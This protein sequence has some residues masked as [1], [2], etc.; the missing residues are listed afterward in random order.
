M[1]T[2]ATAGMDLVHVGAFSG[3]AISLRN[4]LTEIT[5]V[6]ALDLMPLAR[7][8]QLLT[9]RVRAVREARRT[10]PNVPWTKT[11]AWSTAVQANLERQGMFQ[12]SRPL[13]VVQ[14]LPA[15]RL[16]R[17]VRYA[18][19][20]DRVG[21]EGSAVGG[22]HASTFTRGWRA[23]EMELLR[24]ATRVYVMGPSTE[25]VLLEKYGLSPSQIRV[26]GAGPNSVLGPARRRDRCRRLL[27]VG[28]QWQLKGGPELLE[29]FTR[30]RRARP[31]LELVL[32]GSG[33]VGPLPPGVSSLGRVPHQDMNAVYDTADLLVIPTHMEAFGIALVEGLMRGLPCVCSTVGN[34]PWIVADAGVSVPPGDVE[35]LT[36]ALSDAVTG[37]PDLQERAVRRGEALRRTMSWSSVARAIVEDLCGA[38]QAYGRVDGRRS[39]LRAVRREDEASTYGP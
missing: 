22:L 33:P 9:A 16:P 28:T 30:L 35:Q 37:Y 18:V 7:R 4:A 24:A 21:L 19:Y 31:D 15:F 23:R 32:A 36:A 10:G 38:E 14:T 2:G 13:L 20:T 6:R 3:S 27:F 11:A 39:T 29:A 12:P 26:V 5:S 1:T 34:Q 25:S 17:A 8:P